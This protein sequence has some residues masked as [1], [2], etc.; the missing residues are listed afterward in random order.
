MTPLDIF[1]RRGKLSRDIASEVSVENI[2]QAM[3]DIGP[4][5]PATPLVRSTG[6]SDFLLKDVYI[7][8]DNKFTT[9]SFKERGALNFLLKLDADK[10]AKGVCAA[11][12]GNHA[13][14]LSYHSSRL[15]VP[16]TIVM[17][18]NAP[19]VKVETTSRYGAKVILEGDNFDQSYQLAKDLAKSD[20]LTFVPGFDHPDIVAG[21]G[22]CG[23][24]ILEQC[25]DFDS[26]IVAIGGGGL[27]AGVSLAIKSVRPDV[28]VMGVQSTWAEKELASQGHKLAPGTIADG[29]AVKKLGEL[30]KR[31]I[32]QYVDEL[33]QI[34]ED[35][36]A[37]AV[38]K[39]LELEKV[40]VEGAGATGM[41]ALM[42]GALPAQYKKPVVIVCGSNIDMNVLSRLIEREQRRKGRLFRLRVAVPDR[43]GSLAFCT[44]VIAGLSGNII[45]TSH[46]R[47]FS[48]SPGSVDVTFLVEVRNPEHKTTLFSTLTREGLAPSEVYAT[49]D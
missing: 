23:L 39:L 7:K 20:R 3:R 27:A 38:V 35:Q 49:R 24:E 41:A 44:S 22:T 26:C 42:S 12:A 43:P 37:A 10:R 19:L 40:V 46:D 6:F 16:C 48:R 33:I 4:T 45:E 13:L 9:G 32:E 1:R 5:L 21:Q 29:I 8:W 31:I 11:S 14:A 25:S 2:H 47:H 34:D 15:G 36:I 28:F 30:P 18:K 17:P